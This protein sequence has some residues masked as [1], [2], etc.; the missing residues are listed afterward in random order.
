[1]SRLL[2]N[3]FAICSLSLILGGCSDD[4]ARYENVDKLRAFGSSTLPVVSDPSTPEAPKVFTITVFAAVPL[5]ETV[6]AEPY[7]DVAAANV[8]AVPVTI[9]PG[10]EQYEDHATFRIFSVKATQPVPPAS[11][12]E[13][14]LGAPPFVRLRYGIRLVSGGES[15]NVVGNAL[16]YPAGSPQLTRVAP[17]IA[18]TKPATTDVSGT[19]DLEATITDPANENM[20]VGWFSSDGPIKNRRARVTEWETP[21]AGP[22]TLIV[23]I[24]GR[25]TGAFAFQVLD[26]TVQ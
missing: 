7:D 15:E 20:R 11:I 24:R 17:T 19:E 12:F 13:S 22:A 3:L 1:M 5:G 8:A 23:T 2:T 21:S 25:E 26:L 9:V 10:S 16:I 4:E 6:T 14:P 18:I